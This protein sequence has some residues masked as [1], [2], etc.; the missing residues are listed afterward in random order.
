MQQYS[1]SAPLRKLPMSTL[2]PV[3]QPLQPATL[4]PAALQPVAQPLQPSTLQPAALQPATLQPCS[5]QLCNLHPCSLQMRKGS[6]AL[7]PGRWLDGPLARK[8]FFIA[9]GKWS[10]LPLANR[11]AGVQL[12]VR[13]RGVWYGGVLCRVVV[14][15]GGVGVGALYA[16]IQT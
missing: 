13:L 6:A 3:A 10:R 1:V 11:L 5:Q 16:N 15:C 12:W 4:Q 8:L 2:Q 9:P 7:V 14:W